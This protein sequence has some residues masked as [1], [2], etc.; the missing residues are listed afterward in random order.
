[1]ET[2]Q[3]RELL[4][5]W[6]ALGIA[7]IVPPAIVLVAVSDPVSRAMFGTPDVAFA[8]DLVGL[9]IVGGMVYTISLGVL[10]TT[11]RPLAYAMLEGGALVANAV[12]AIA[13][14][15]WWRADATAVMLALALVWSAA[16]IT[17]LWSVRASISAEPNRT[18]A[19]DLLRLGL[20]LAPAVAATFGADFFNRAFLLG[21]AG[22]TEAGYLSIAI[23]IAS[24]A[25][26]IVA[27]TQLAWQ[28]HA[29]R[30]GTRPR[31]LSRLG[32]EANVI[33]IGLAAGGS[34]H[35]P[36]VP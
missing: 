10:R 24:V 16:A 19:G 20:P 11:G 15:V 21:S 30:L 31:P 23:R 7:F 6:Y 1:M 33:V 13:L 28:P 36:A 22:A 3:R 14:L 35:R 4:S 29:Y 32:R 26:L 18:A 5:S 2:H 8:L 9:V 27:A 17:G 34:D 12:L 25:G